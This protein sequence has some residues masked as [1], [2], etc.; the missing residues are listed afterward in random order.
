MK[1]V[2]FIAF[3]VLFAGAQA[4]PWKNQ[5]WKDKL[6]VVP[7]LGLNSS[8]LTQTSTRA[9]FGFTGGVGLRI[10]KRKHL[11][12]GLY[13]KAVRY[14][15][16]IDTAGTSMPTFR[17]VRSD[18]L[19]V[20]LMFGLTPIKAP[21]FELRVFGGAAAFFNQSGEVSGLSSISLSQ[22]MWNLRAGAGIDIWRI[23]CNFS[24]DFGITKMFETVSD[25]KYHGYNLTL[26]FRF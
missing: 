24:Y 19:V 25:G 8:S 15:A 7:E 20:P 10:G 17:K 18:Y 4:N 2:F 9:S 6:S 22:T 5:L 1:N 13:Y 26:G 16:A 11:Y 23:E 12:S 3:M 21:M 14:E